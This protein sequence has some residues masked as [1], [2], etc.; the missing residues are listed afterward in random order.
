MK[1]IKGLD[2]RLMSLQQRLIAAKQFVQD[3][4]DMSQVSYLFLFHL[5]SEPPYIN[6]SRA[7]VGTMVPHAV[8]FQ[9]A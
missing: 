9:S 3:Q 4:S 2:D 5:G 1:E 8:R 6:G 7:E